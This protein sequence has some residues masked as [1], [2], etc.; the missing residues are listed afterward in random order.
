VTPENVPN[1]ECHKCMD[2]DWTQGLAGYEYQLEPLPI[3]A[4]GSSSA[5]ITNRNFIEAE[6]YCQSLGGNAHLASVSSMGE[7][8]ALAKAFSAE[9]GNT[10]LTKVWIGMT[11]MNID[12]GKLYVRQAET[13][14]LSRALSLA[15]VQ[16]P[17][18]PIEC[19]RLPFAWCLGACVCTV[20]TRTR[21]AFLALRAR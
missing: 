21:P 10:K 1:G 17:P 3:H 2:G 11:T 6:K 19:G 20:L 15:T 5:T 14:R 8:L 13:L 4:T 18:A 16:P 7:R 12:T 9:I